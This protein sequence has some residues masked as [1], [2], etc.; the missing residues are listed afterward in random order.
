MALSA[1]DSGA[2]WSRVLV[3]VF[4]DSPLTLLVTLAACGLMV[5]GWYA[6]RKQIHNIAE[7]SDGFTGAAP[8]L[9]NRTPIH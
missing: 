7:T 4:I 5:G 6:C 9:A 1:D 8:V 3:M 2:L